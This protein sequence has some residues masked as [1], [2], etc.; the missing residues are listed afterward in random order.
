MIGNSPLRPF[1]L[2]ELLEQLG[3]VPHGRGHYTLECFVVLDPG[4]LA[5]RVLP[6][7]P[8]C[9]VF[10]NLGRNRFRD[11]SVHPVLIRPMYSANKSLNPDPAAGI[12]RI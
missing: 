11:H 3:G 6:R 4:I 1:V 7:V 10:R 8:K 9:A 5:V 12:C 2:H